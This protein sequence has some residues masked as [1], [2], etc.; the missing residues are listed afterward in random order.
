MTP[1]RKPFPV[2]WLS[3]GVVVFIALAGVISAFAITGNETRRNKE[4]IVEMKKELS[5]NSVEHKAIMQGI[6]DIKVSLVEV[7]TKMDICMQP[8]A[9]QRYSFTLRHRDSTR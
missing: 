2:Q 9:P 7:K 1:H 5:L 4:D 6:G 3:V 8:G